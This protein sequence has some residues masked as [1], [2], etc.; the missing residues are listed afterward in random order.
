MCWGATMRPRNGKRSRLRLE[1]EA[2]RR[3]CREVLERDGWRCQ[4]C[5]IARDLQ[6]HHLGPRSQLGGDTEKNLITL[7]AHRHRNRHGHA[8][9]AF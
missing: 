9:L 6:V 4:D 3:L 8:K 5:G 7:C 1:P 2:Y